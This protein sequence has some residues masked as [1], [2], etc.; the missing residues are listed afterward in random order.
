MAVSTGTPE[1]CFSVR[2]NTVNALLVKRLGYRRALNVEVFV[3]LW[4]MFV[5]VEGRTP[6]NLDEL[7]DSIGRDRATVYRWQSF[8]REAFPQWA[9]PQE[10]LDA[11][12]VEGPMTVPQVAELPVKGS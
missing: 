8:F 2:R 5:T 12:G 7:A 11:A 6:E 4:T 10:L 1:R 9:T 3:M